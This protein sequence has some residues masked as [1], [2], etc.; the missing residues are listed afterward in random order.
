[1]SDLKSVVSEFL[2][3]H[4]DYVRDLFRGYYEDSIPEEL[5]AMGL[6]LVD[7]DSYGGEGKGEEYWHVYS[8]TNGTE[9][10]YVKFDGYYASYSGS[11]F[12]EWFFVE[13]KEVTVTQYFR[14][15]K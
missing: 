12:Q 14:V 6:T 11:E 10:V 2:N 8:I 7:E 4:R 15:S 13:P 5:T 9:T 1:M 3:A